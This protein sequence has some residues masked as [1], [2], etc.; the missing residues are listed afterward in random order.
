MKL[1]ELPHDHPGV[2]DPVYRQR[3]AEIADVSAAWRPGRPL[4]HID[5]LAAEHEVWSTVMSNL[6]P[7]HRKYTSQAFLAGVDALDLSTEH[8]PQ[9]AEVDRRLRE[10]SRF[11][12]EPVAGLVP[13]RRFYGR[14]ADSVF[15]STQYLRHETVPLYTPEPDVVHE[16]VGHGNLLAN[17]TFAELHRLAGACANRCRADV[18]LEYFSRVFWFTLEFGVV[19]EAG[20]IKAYGAGLAS[21]FGELKEFR[22]AEMRPF[23]LDAMGRLDY[24]I[25]TYQPVLF[26][27]DGI[28]ELADR[29]GT[30]FASF[31]DDEYGRLAA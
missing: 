19:R 29:L 9:L 2:H 3:R 16:I 21:S 15:L 31:D 11:G 8:L 5:Y 10:V 28:A 27:V 25:S 14:L 6:E 20:E 22:H 26:V 18:A 23:D 7:L 13:T 12:L 30:F 4:P 1:A 17:P 24:D